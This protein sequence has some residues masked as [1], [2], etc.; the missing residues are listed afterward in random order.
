[1]VSILPNP[2]NAAW[3]HPGSPST[4]LPLA[5]TS[6]YQMFPGKPPYQ[7]MTSVCP[8][9]SYMSG[10]LHELGGNSG[11]YRL[12]IL[13]CFYRLLKEWLNDIWFSY[14]SLPRLVETRKPLVSPDPL[15]EPNPNSKHRNNIPNGSVP[16]LR[17]N[18]QNGSLHLKKITC[19]VCNSM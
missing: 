19:Q 1:M 10:Y 11:V 18:I 5:I 8:L 7:R 15:L 14:V 2:T 9:P 17:K 16:Y 13:K 12:E 3:H 6:H 4:H